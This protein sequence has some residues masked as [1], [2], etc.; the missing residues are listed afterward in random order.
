[1]RRLF[2]LT[3]IACAL[4][5]TA[6][7]SNDITVPD[8]SGT[9]PATGTSLWTVSGS[10]SSILRLDPTLL[11]D[12]ARGITTVITTPSANLNTLAAVAFDTTG[13]LWIV[14][15]DEPLLLGFAPGTL[16]SSGEKR[17]RTT[18][19]PEDST[20]ASPTGLAFDAKQR[21]WVADFSGTLNRF[22]VDQLTI[23][24]VQSPAVVITVPG[25]LSSIAFDAEGSLWV[26]D[27]VQ[28]VLR[29][30]T[31]D[32]LA[33]SGS[34]V[35]DVVLTANNTSLAN[36]SGLAFDRF[37]NL[38]VANIG[39]RTLSSFSPGQLNRSGSPAPNV[40]ITSIAG[41]LSVPVGLAFDADG[42]LW[43]VGGTGALT[44][45]SP[46]A[47]S[48]SGAAAP[49]L[50][51]QI[52]EGSLFWNIAFWPIPQGLPLGQR[53]SGPYLNITR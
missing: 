40:Q 27:N 13:A 30:Y 47:L 49:M 14:G 44:R 20:I 33:H 31:A 9:P 4:S 42:S 45:Y 10:A 35:P 21:L 39:G 53:P 11:G 28:S 2:Q 18:I 23:G 41:A 16:T 24:G 52:A 38:W 19:I 15:F 37:G 36:P 25:N 8:S 17:A 3:A 29:K 50:R 48:E 46:A 26:S 43:V 1:M 5:V 22:D 32:Q 7:C 34:P 51:S 12:S 6:S